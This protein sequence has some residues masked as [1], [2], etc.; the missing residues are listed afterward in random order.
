M[1][2]IT[3]TKVM[4][5]AREFGKALANCEEYLAVER[6]EDA[7]RKDS[8]A[9]KLLSDY[10]STQRSVQ[11]ARMWGGRIAKDELDGLRSLE[12][13]IN[14]NQIIKNL[15]DAQKRLPEMLGNLNTEISDLLGIDFASNSTVGGCC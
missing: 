6:A 10:Q 2:V 12:A 4:E 8:Q 11:M 15:L 13:K 9:R 3:K 7:L 5:T 1:E 14:S